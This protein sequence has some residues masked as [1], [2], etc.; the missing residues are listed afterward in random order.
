MEVLK[1]G[2]RILWWENVPGDPIPNPKTVDD[3][4]QFPE[5]VVREVLEWLEATQNEKPDPITITFK[6]ISLLRGMQSGSMNQ[7]KA[8]I[9][10][11][12]R[13]AFNPLDPLAGLPSLA[14]LTYEIHG[15]T[16]KGIGAFSFKRQHLTL[17]MHDPITFHFRFVAAVDDKKRVI[18]GPLIEKTQ[19]ARLEVAS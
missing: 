18:L 17:T 6:D 11:S 13:K 14:N 10:S 1:K 12:W 5:P 8:Q 15:G 2:P 7:I 4:G 19:L 16:P 3:R 9:E